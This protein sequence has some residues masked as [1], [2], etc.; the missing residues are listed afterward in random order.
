MAIWKFQKSNSF[1][2]ETIDE[3]IEKI[4]HDNEFAK[5]W[6]DIGPVYGKQWINF[7]G[8]NQLKKNF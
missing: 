6:G 7:N 8:I 3:F 2:N 1:K 5:K 4:K